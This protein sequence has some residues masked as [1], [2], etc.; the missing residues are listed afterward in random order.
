M[1]YMVLVLLEYNFVQETFIELSIQQG[2]LDSSVQIIPT[3]DNLKGLFK[4]SD[5]VR[6]TFTISLK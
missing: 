5:K 3:V 4:T 6:D 2:I 1:L